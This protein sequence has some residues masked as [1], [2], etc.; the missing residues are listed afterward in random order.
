[1][2]LGG[3]KFA[4]RFCNKG[5][6]TD[7]QW[8]RLIHKTKVEAFIA[9]SDKS[10]SG[11]VYDMTDS[12]D[13]I[14]HCL[15]SVGNNYVTCFKNPDKSA[16]FAIYTLTYYNRN[17]SPVTGAV[18][19]P[20]WYPKWAGGNYYVGSKSTY[21]IATDDKSIPWNH[22]PDP[23]STNP[24]EPPLLIASICLGH[25][26]SGYTGGSTYYGRDFNTYFDATVNYYGFAVKDENIIMFSGT[27]NTVENLKIALVSQ[28]AFSTLVHDNDT[29]TVFYTNF[30]TDDSNSRENAARSFSGKLSIA[31]TKNNL[32]VPEVPKWGF[33]PMSG[34]SGSVQNYPYQAVSVTDVANTQN[35]NTAK[36]NINIDLVAANMQTINS[37]ASP[38]IFSTAAG[39]K[40]LTVTKY[41][42]SFSFS[43]YC[44]GKTRE[45]TYPGWTSIYVGWDPS[46]PD[47]L[48]SSAWTEVVEE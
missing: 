27:A 11:W 44:T 6:L 39:G 18:Y 40:L 34:Y 8:S 30:Q 15:D 21:F 16:F 25:G 42:T 4:G 19:A 7:T 41:T 48:T 12:P 31:M 9:A 28:N 35:L 17:T 20:L 45:T 13:G 22:I 14:Y 38:N 23:D 24:T 3:Y 36:G 10:H 47:I 37:S 29:H 5:S 43:V 32:G 26:A 1:M 46:N 33:F 2:A